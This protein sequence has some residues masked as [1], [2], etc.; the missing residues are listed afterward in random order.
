MGKLE[1]KLIL[2]ASSD[3]QIQKRKKVQICTIWCTN[4]LFGT[5]CPLIS[6]DLCASQIHEKFKMRLLSKGPFNSARFNSKRTY[7]LIKF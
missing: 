4:L 5:Y 6:K 3:F 7:Q 2:N 1:Q